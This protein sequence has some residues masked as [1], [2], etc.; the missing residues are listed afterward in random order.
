MPAPNK[1]RQDVDKEPEET[2]MSENEN[3]AVKVL[4]AGAVEFVITDLAGRF[5]RE[6]GVPVKFTFGTIAGV[7]KR[8]IS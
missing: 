1:L 2:P 6:N 8:L 4:S 5:E 7:K 3:A